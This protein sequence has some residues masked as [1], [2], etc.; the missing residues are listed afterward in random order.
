MRPIATDGVAWFV[1]L[2]VAFVS[3]AKMAEP[4][5]RPFGWVTWVGQRN[6]VL[7]IA[8]Q[9][10][11]GKGQC[12]GVV[13]TCP[14]RWK[15]LGVTAAVY[16]AKQSITAS[17][18]LLQ[19]TA[20]LPTL[21]VTLNFPREKINPPTTAMRPFVKIIWPLVFRS[22]QRGS[23]TRSSWKVLKKNY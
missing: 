22:F 2:L 16:A 18:R 3:P 10:P 7:S 20:L 6:H 21:G 23:G 17:A 1:C 8:V 15:A 19:M 4:I 5:E 14:A 13:P 11:N 12:L 9:K